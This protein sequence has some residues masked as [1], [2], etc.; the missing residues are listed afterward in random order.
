MLKELRPA[1]VV[2]LLMTAI[3]G[4]IYPLAIT[5]IAQTAFPSAANGSLIVKDGKVIG[6]ELIAQSFT[7]PE[8]FHP[9]PSAVNYDAASSGGSNAAPSSRKL[10][11][12]IADRTKALRAELGEIQIPIELVT[13]SGSGL[14]PHISFNAAWAQAKRV[15]EARESKGQK[16]AEGDVLKLIASHIEHRTL[17]VLGE[18][19]VNV[20]RLNLA[21]DALPKT[22]PAPR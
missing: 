18:P 12:D 1:L 20:L 4:V 7:R 10:I 6:S 8:Y 2:V 13:T 15:A 11:A 9:R 17:S 5:G 21:L 16:M 19:R 3:T 22:A 14:D